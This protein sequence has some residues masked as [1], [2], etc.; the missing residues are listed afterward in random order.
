MEDVVKVLSNKMII[1]YVLESENGSSVHIMSCGYKGDML[2][3]QL[4]TNAYC[5]TLKK[6]VEGIK[7]PWKGRKLFPRLFIKASFYLK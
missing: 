7:I 5:K 1:E 6:L 4:A 3:I 2:L